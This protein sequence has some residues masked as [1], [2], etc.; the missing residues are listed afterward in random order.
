[1][2]AGFLEQATAAR[3]RYIE[4]FRKVAGELQVDPSCAIEV[5]VQPNDRTTPSPFCMMRVDAIIG[6]AASP[7]VQR[8]ADELV[9]DPR[10]D[11][12]FSNRLQIVQEGFSWEALRLAFSAPK[13]DV[14]VLGPWLQA[15][16][17]VEE[18]REPDSFG[19]SGVVH[20]LAWQQVAVSDWVLYVDLGSAGLETL[21]ELLE[22]VAA[23]GA[24]RVEVSRHDDEDA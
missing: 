2:S 23:A 16:L 14:T 21:V 18:T 11:F 10:S 3:E 20:D 19:L 6:G 13:F 1:M 17:D 15:W 4:H 7:R 22:L 24:R 12:S 8:V 9:V 5:L